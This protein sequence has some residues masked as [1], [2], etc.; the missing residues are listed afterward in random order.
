MAET[1]RTSHS[2]SAAGMTAV[3]GS[4]K[5]PMKH[6]F[7]EISIHPAANGYTLK[8]HPPREEPKSE[9]AMYMPRPEPTE[10]VFSGTDAGQAML[11]HIGSILGVGKAPG[12]KDQKSGKEGDKKPA[13]GKMDKEDKKDEGKNDEDEEESED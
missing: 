10:S 1:E 9:K 12:N 2:K 7:H 11:D 4:K 3:S 5:G 6:K 8:H 13:S